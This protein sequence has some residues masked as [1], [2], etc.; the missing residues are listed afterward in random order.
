MDEDPSYMPFESLCGEGTLK[1]LKYIIKQTE[2][3]H[4]NI[5]FFH[6]PG[7]YGNYEHD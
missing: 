6:F 5:N 2:K 3:L 1:M 7:T 4:L